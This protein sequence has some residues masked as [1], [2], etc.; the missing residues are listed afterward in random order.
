MSRRG[1]P[2]TGLVISSLLATGLMALN[3]T[4][5]LVE[6]FTFI[7]LLATLSTLVPYV[8]SAVAE[9]VIFTRERKKFRGERLAGASVIAV[10]ALLYSLWAIVGSGRETVFWGFGLMLAGLPIYFWQTRKINVR[11]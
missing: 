2:V 3:Y 5:S 11:G 7:I 4:A 1:T 9:L 6:Q 10:L 8:F